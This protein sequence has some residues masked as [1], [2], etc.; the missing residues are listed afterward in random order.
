MKA[1]YDF[2]KKITYDIGAAFFGSKEFPYDPRSVKADA[3]PINY[4]FALVNSAKFY[5]DFDNDGIPVANYLN[6]GFQYNPTRIASYALAHYSRY[7][8]D[9]KPE[10]KSVFLNTANWFLNEK[11]ARFEYKYNYD[12]LKAPWISCMAQGQGISVLVRAYKLT[13]DEK[14]LK[15]AILA[16]Q[17]FG[18]SVKKGG[19]RSFREGLGYFLEEFPFPNRPWTVLNG[20]LYAIIGII[21][22]QN[23]YPEIDNEVGLQKLITSAAKGHL[24]THKDWTC[25][26]LQNIGT[27][28]RNA[29]TVNYHRVHIAQYQYLANLFPKLGFDV[30]AN[31]WTKQYN[32][33]IKRTNALKNKIIFRTK[34]PANRF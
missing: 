13:N 15:Q 4:E 8:F 27:T 18:I 24:W 33:L 32:S 2:A 7:Q 10:S 3:Y 11:N 20:F 34:N 5:P 30:Y 28:K 31:L 29:A 25:Y 23:H 12:Q 9:D 1:Y 19:L 21:E 17:P 26:D 16:A 14:Y 6:A 22:L